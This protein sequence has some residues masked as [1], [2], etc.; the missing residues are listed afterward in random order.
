MRR[1][2]RVLAALALTLIG[3]DVL[4]NF[5]FVIMNTAL[6]ALTFIIVAATIAVMS[7]AK[8]KD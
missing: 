8:D 1:K 2:A 6:D 5:S 3:V 4:V 7:R